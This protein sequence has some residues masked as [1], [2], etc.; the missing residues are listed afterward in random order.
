MATV[1]AINSK[2]SIGRAIVYVLQEKKRINETGMPDEELVSGILCVPFNAGAQMEITKRIWGKTG[3][4]TYKHYTQSFAPGEA[5]P[6]LAHEI[7]M[8]LAG[9]IRPWEGFEVLVV[10]HTDKE[11]FHNHFIVNSVNVHDGHKLQW[12]RSDLAEMK[13]IND[14]LCRENGL[15]VPVKG[16]TYDGKVRKDT[17][18]YSRPFY[19]NFMKET[20]TEMD[21][22]IFAIAMAVM[23]AKE[24]ATS[25]QEFCFLL[26]EENIRV[27]WEEKRKYITFTDLERER[28]GE[29]KCK[30]RNSKLEELFHVDF[31]KEALLDEF[32]RNLQAETRRQN[33]GAG[34]ADLSSFLGE[35]K[36]EESLAGKERTDREAAKQR[37]RISESKR[38]PAPVR[39]DEKERRGRTEPVRTDPVRSEA[40]TDRGR[41]DDEL[42]L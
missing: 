24:I 21:S 28:A 7:G 3:G 20:G 8:K 34:E 16:M 15:T 31:G 4:R 22:Y 26:A 32:N 9:K 25:R 42:C 14:E 18:T 29:K 19:E 13:N 12:K 40:E 41:G 30:V 37:Q 36:A 10:T 1:K 11:Y 5:T 33:P 39:T 2:A 23:Q 27:T 35:L 17:T 38:D 6:E